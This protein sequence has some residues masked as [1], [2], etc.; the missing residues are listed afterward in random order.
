MKVR[1][2]ALACVAGV[3]LTT[4][5]AVL[6]WTLSASAGQP[7]MHTDTAHTTPPFPSPGGWE[8]LFTFGR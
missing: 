1:R 7:E 5:V 4:T 8:H 6:G 2:W 3:A